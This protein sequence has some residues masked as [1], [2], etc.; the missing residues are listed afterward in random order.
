MST[1]FYLVRHAIK[2]KDVGDVPISVEGLEQANVTA[3]YLEY[4]PISRIFSSP[5]KRAKQ[6][7]QI[8][9]KA[10]KI[11]IDEDIRLR[12]RANWGD[13]PG[14]TFEEFVAMW[15]QCTRERDFLPPIGDSARMA[16]ERLSSCL[17]GLSAQYPNE[18]I[19]IVT[20][21]GLI[22]DFM[23]NE[24]S[25]DELNNTHTNFITEQSNLIGE[26]S[27]TRISCDGR[28][29]NLYEFANIA[30]LSC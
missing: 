12:E 15:N 30:H 25:Q 24:F 23:L 3:K 13:L 17:I 20:H 8:I 27:I 7:A 10:A 6:T 14:Q 21:G 11:P 1:D 29:F 19:V 28:A 16:G 22:T 18:S 9:G 4:F 26:C 5:L 2:E